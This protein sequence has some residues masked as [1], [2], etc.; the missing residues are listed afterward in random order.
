MIRRDAKKDARRVYSKAQFTYV[1]WDGVGL[2]KEIGRPKF[3]LEI[4]DGQRAVG[5]LLGTSRHSR[6]AL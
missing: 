6:M 2:P 1:N 5:K 3:S 4:V